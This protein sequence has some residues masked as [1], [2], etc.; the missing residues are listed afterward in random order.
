[1]KYSFSTQPPVFTIL[2]F[3]IA[4]LGAETL[5]DYFISR[6]I[7]ENY[8]FSYHNK[9]IVRRFQKCLNKEMQTHVNF[10]QMFGLDNINQLND[11]WLESEN[12]CKIVL[13]KFDWENKTYSETKYNQWRL[14]KP[15]Q[16]PYILNK[17]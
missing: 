15:L 13:L 5:K 9:K 14:N 4:V 16:Y 6:Q 3:G 1:M 17:S 2:I 7:Y 11:R 10:A 12:A 8:D